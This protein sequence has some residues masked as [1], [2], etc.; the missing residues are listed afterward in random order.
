MPAGSWWF[1]ILALPILFVIVFVKAGGSGSPGS[2]G[3]DQSAKILG[4]MAGGGSQ[5]ISTLEGN[6]AGAS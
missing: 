6:P 1:W 5:L 4:A 3:G 2:S